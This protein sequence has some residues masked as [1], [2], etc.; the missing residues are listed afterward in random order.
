MDRRGFLASAGVAAGLLAG[1]VGDLETATADVTL[2]AFSDETALAV[3]N[4]NGD[5]T[6]STAERSSATVRLTK[7]TRR[8]VDLDRVSITR[9]VTDGT[10]AVAPDLPEGVQAGDVSIDMAFELPLDARLAVVQTSNGDVTVDGGR[11][12]A[13]VRTTNGTATAR[14]LDGFVTVLTSNGDA[15]ARDVRGVD[16]LGSINGSV[17]AD[18]PAIRG[19]VTAETTNG[20]V[21][22][23][24][25]PALDARV[26][27]S[28]VNGSVSVTGLSL[29]D[30]VIRDRRVTGRLGDGGRTLDARTTNGSVVVEA[31]A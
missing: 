2:S 18:V 15:R 6:V 28:T 27:A 9:E 26:E 8:G 14:N 30:A 29:A 17:R 31:L 25:A 12:D 1:C 5:V 23:A 21:R 3:R 13:T 10:L 24:L 11:G 7:R 20:D 4:Q 16:R 22:L 19:D